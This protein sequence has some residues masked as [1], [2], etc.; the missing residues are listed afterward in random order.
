MRRQNVTP[1]EAWHE[2]EMACDRSTFDTV[3][4]RVGWLINDAL[5]QAA[6]AAQPDPGDPHHIL[7]DMDVMEARRNLRIAI[8]REL[9]GPDPMR[10]ERLERAIFELILAFLAVAA[11]SK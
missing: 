5:E 11:Q 8:E 6:L 10:G 2:I 7:A 1:D 4:K 9:P 3:R